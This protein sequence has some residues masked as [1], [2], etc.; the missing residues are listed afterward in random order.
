MAIYKC[1]KTGSAC[2]LWIWYENEC[3]GLA[4]DGKTVT[5]GTIRVARKRGAK[6]NAGMQESWRQEL[7]DSSVGVLENVAPLQILRNSL[8]L[9]IQYKISQ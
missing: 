1:T 4:A 6:S 2:K 9:Y 3:G 8:R 7:Q 5:W